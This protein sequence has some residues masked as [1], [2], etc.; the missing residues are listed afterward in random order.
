[1]LGFDTYKLDQGIS[2]PKGESLDI[3]ACHFNWLRHCF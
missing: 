1:M 2:N 3:G